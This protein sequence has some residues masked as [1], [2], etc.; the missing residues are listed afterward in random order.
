M[1]EGGDN[2]PPHGATKKLGGRIS[3]QSDS[4]LTVSLICKWV[5]GGCIVCWVGGNETRCQV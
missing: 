3:Q 1:G 5:S 2:C 4:S